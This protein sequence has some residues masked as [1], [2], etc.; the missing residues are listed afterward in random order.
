MNAL[1][2]ETNMSEIETQRLERC[3][4]CAKSEETDNFMGLGIKA[5]I[6]PLHGFECSEVVQCVYVSDNKRYE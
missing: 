5:L 6:C 3:K 4:K 1:A 2:R